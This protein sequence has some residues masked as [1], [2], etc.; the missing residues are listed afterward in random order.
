LLALLIVSL[1]YAELDYHRGALLRYALFFLPV[2]I[3]ATVSGAALMRATT[4]A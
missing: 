3:A 2:G 1:S 4:R